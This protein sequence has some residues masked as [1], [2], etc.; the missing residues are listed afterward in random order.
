MNKINATAI[1]TLLCDFYKTAHKDQYKPNTSLI[2]STWTPRS[3][4]HLQQ[5]DRVVQFGLQAFIRKYLMSYFDDAF[6]KRTE[7]EV[8]TEY[9]EFIKRTLGT[10]VTGEHIRELHQLGY[11]PIRIKAIPEGKST[12]IRVPLLTIENTNSKFFWI[13]N[14]LET[15]LSTSLWQPST[16]ASI[17]RQYRKLLTAYGLA[18]CDDLSHVQFQAHD[19]SMRGMSSLESAET[20]GAGHLTSFLGTDTIPAINYV[21]AYYP[22][23]GQLVGTSIPACYDS[24]TEVLTNKGWKKFEHLTEEDKVAQYTPNGEIEFVKPT[25]YYNMPYTGKMCRYSWKTKVKYVDL[26]VTPN[27]KMIKRN[28]NGELELFEAV[29]NRYKVKGSKF[30]VSGIKSQGV[31]F[32]LSDLERF[33]IAF[34]ADGSFFSKRVF[35]GQ[36]TGARSGTFPVRFNLKKPRKIERLGNILDALGWEYNKT[37]SKSREGYVDF[38]IKVPIDLK[39]KISKSFKDWVNLED[40]TSSWGLSF[41]DELKYWDGKS[42]GSSGVGYFTISKDNA[43]MVQAISH[44]SGCKDKLSADN[45]S[46]V[47]GNRQI[48]YDSNIIPKTTVD[49]RG[50]TYNEVD[51][52]G[53]VHCVS[54]P[55]KMLVV[56]RNNVVAI[57]GNTEH[58][59]MCSHGMNELETF[60]FLIEDVYPKGFVS[61]VSDTWDFWKNIE[62]T[63]PALKD[64]IMARDGKVVIRPDSGDPV[65]ILVG[66]VPVR[67]LE[68]VQA[69]EEGSGYFLKDGKVVKITKAA[70]EEPKISPD[71]RTSEE[72]GLIECLWEIFGGYTNEKGYRVLDSHIGA[73]Y[74]DSITLQRAEQIL[75]GLQSKK[76]ASSN[77]VFGV[78]SFTYQY[79]TRDSLGFAMKATYAIIEGK[80]T[81]LFKDPKTD[82]GTKKSQKGLVAVLE[83]GSA[84]VDGLYQ[85]SPELNQSEL[86]TVFDNGELL[87]VFTWEEVK[88]NIQYEIE[89]EL[90]NGL[91]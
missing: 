1:P 81:H 53:T 83:N 11:L 50:I 29:D 82:N 48:G 26:L 34:Q 67:N 75:H 31:S 35:E 38:Y 59:V 41:I 57:C 3:N 5:V 72:K 64:K 70:G 4:Q 49:N 2:Y 7:D 21:E 79:L 89:Q 37:P 45:P 20:S 22:T 63:L 77:I 6:F 23:N 69:L 44:L 78:G 46:K 80:E 71:D 28:K 55:T 42:T 51:Y 12:A 84:V 36:Y 90:E 62:E 30:I 13:T 76:F 9:V 24:E 18:T 15:L 32:E 52:S 60:R 43:D 61:I 33:L 25:A 58:S 27:H 10:D 19:F 14:Y 87:K 47:R 73:I 85:D 16:S 8:V 54:V 40:I 68:L 65:S 39:D 91:R 66:T 56:R 86:E 17:A 88:E 74:G